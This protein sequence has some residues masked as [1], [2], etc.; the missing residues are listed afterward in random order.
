MK[1]AKIIIFF[2]LIS[3]SANAQKFKLGRV[4]E[5]ELLEKR[6]PI[7]T[8]AAAAILHKKGK[9][10]FEING[11]YWNLVTEVETKIKIYKKE[12]YEYAT[13]EVGYY[14]GGRT[15]K[16]FFTDAYTYNLE[17]GKIE[18]TKLKTD[19][20][21]EEKVNENYTIEK[22][23]MPNVREG[24]VIEYK[25]V[26]KSPYFSFF[27]D[28]YFQYNIPVN[29]IEYEVAI[30]VYFEYNRY[31]AGATSIQQ[32]EAKTRSGLGS[33]FQEN[34]ITYSAKDVRALK[35]EAYVNNIRNYMSILKHELA[36]VRMPNSNPEFYADN[37]ES[38]SKKIYEHKGFGKELKLNS[39]FQDDIKELLKTTPKSEEKVIAIFNYVK[40]RMTWNE[41]NSYYCDKGVK[42]AYTDKVGNTAEI[43]LMLV[44]MLRFAG[45]NANPVLISTRSNGVALYPNRNAYNYIVAGVLMDGE[46]VLFDATSKYALPG[47][48][49]VRALNWNGR[50][51]RENGTTHEVDLIP[52]V[53]SKEIIQVSAQINSS[54]KVTGKARDQYYDYNAYRFRENYLG[55]S[56]DSYLEAMEK[57]YGGV[58]IDDY[59]T[60]YDKDLSKPMLEEY[61]FVHNGLTDIIGDRMYINPML[62]FRQAE[63]PF[64]QEIREYPIDFVYP[65]QDKYMISIII[66]E[67]YEI[68]FAPESIAL[69]MEENIGSFKYNIN[70]EKNIIQLSV[71]LDINYANISQNY[72]T[73]LRSFYQKL[74]EKQNE[75]IILKKV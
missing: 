41:K 64:K 72:Y 18:K 60:L 74:I 32:S 35:P 61:S 29:E 73:A 55:M 7:D 20:K 68:E 49:P 46:Q 59:K 37:W 26:I 66:P 8:S 34:V 54:G 6:H 71:A 13:E 40:N 19:G 42:R 5:Q 9:S 67:G 50:L 65:R 33:G 38:V 70:A 17:D 52:K 21:F 25:Y 15:L 51:I 56:K 3:V 69:A 23:T 27:R 28:W 43:N 10:Y 22:I 36:V 45:F 12:G 4:T 2:L 39:Y 16:V 44:S 24:S 48:L 1:I 63:N 53:N 31:L 14:S 75:K 58:E 62:Y 11:G 47:L 57:R 30:P